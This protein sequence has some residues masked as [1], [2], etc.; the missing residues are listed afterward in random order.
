MM[1]FLMKVTKGG[2]KV[3]NRDVKVMNPVLKVMKH[4]SKVMNDSPALLIT[5]YPNHSAVQHP[6]SL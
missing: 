2:S 5:S 4:P 6:G 3:M 1:P